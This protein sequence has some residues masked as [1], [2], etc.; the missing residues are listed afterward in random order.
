VIPLFVYSNASKRCVCGFIGALLLMPMLVSA[1]VV[2][3]TAPAS[4]VPELQF[5]GY[6]G[7]AYELN[8]GKMLYKETHYIKFVKSVVAERVVIYRCPNNEPFGRKVLVMNKSPLIPEF[9][10]NDSRTGHAE[11]LKMDGAK[12]AISF[13]QNGKK[14]LKTE[15]I[16]V[17][18]AMVAD[19]GFDEFIRLN[20]TSLRAGT[21]APLNFIVPSQLD[22]LGFKVKYLRAVM[23]D[24]KPASV[25]K[26][27]PSGVLSLFTSGLDVTYLDEDRSLRQ[28]A[29]LSNIRDLGGEN[30][31]VKIDFPLNLRQVYADQTAMQAARSV[32]LVQRCN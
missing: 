2:A 25:F 19:A 6:E 3:P 22:Y 1:Q 32:A 21:S 9:S 24:Q 13:R 17:T 18:A 11:G 29:G 5:K 20:W 4:A 27:A 28:F 23:L 26:L 31:E 10:F 16:D 8:S 30:Y 7:L 14:S 12:L 15:K